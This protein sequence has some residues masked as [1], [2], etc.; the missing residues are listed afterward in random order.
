MTEEPQYE[1]T[2]GELIDIVS[3]NH[4]KIILKQRNATAQE[5]NLNLIKDIDLVGKDVPF[6]ANFIKLVIMLAQTNYHIWHCR[7]NTQVE[8][9]HKYN[10]IRNLLKN[11]LSAKAN[12]NAPELKFNENEL[13]ELGFEI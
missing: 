13:K 5:D 11:K 8:E 2:L 6:D 3:I 9:A 12:E 4:I 1:L 7:A 10:S